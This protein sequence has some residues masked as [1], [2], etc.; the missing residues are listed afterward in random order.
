MELGHFGKEYAGEKAIISLT[1][2]KARIN[3]VG[4]TIFNLLKTCPGFHIVLVLAEEEFPAK[5]AK[6][7]KQLAAMAN[8]GLFEILWVERNWKSF[9]KIL[10]TMEKYPSVPIISADDDCLYKFNYAEELLSNLPAHRPA[11]V[12][13][14]CS[15]YK[16][17]N[18][19]NTAGYATC[20]SPN[21]F[22]G[23]AH[24]VTDAVMP[25]NEDDMLYLALR[26]KN[27]I[28]GCVCLHKSYNEVASAHHEINPLHNMYAKR[29]KAQ[30][31]AQID[32]LVQILYSTP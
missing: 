11:C 16:D 22:S 10:F 26:I 28:Q 32:N 25:F 24:F 23:A 14:W 15:S 9:K 12:T 21:Y 20:F 30:R 3:T 2:W 4:L 6:L 13:Y 18:Y 29:S 17:S 8:A 7:P 27:N 19:Y 5:E 31:D 1:S